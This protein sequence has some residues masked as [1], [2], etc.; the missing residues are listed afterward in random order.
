[1]FRSYTQGHVDCKRSV[2]TFV[3]GVDR[4]NLNIDSRLPQET[5]PSVASRW[6]VAMSIIN[7]LIEWTLAG[8]VKGH[9][10]SHRRQQGCAA[11]AVTL[12]L[13]AWRPPLHRCIT[14][15]SRAEAVL[16]AVCI[17]ITTEAFIERS[18]A[19]NTPHT[20]RRHSVVVSQVNSLGNWSRNWRLHCVQSK[21]NYYFSMIEN[22]RV[23]FIFTAHSQLNRL[24]IIGF[25]C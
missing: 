15:L 17:A 11:P 9:L 19:V 6:S 20:S 21:R 16:C 10:S 25:L 24:Q 5:L 7:A 1:M 2:S 3:R 8:V 22:K 23:L 4:C 12:L 14:A 18:P 13:I